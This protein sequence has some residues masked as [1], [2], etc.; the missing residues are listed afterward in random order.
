M[1]FAIG[2]AVS[3]NATNVSRVGRCWANAVGATF[4]L[5]VGQTLIQRINNR[6]FFH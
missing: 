2:F 6:Y 1:K 5:F 4:A 3:Q